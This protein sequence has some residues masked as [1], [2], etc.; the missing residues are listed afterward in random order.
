[1]ASF[2][3]PK[4]SEQLGTPGLEADFNWK[5]LKEAFLWRYKRTKLTRKRE[6]G[7]Y[8]IR[9]DTF[10][11]KTGLQDARLD[12]YS[13]KTLVAT[14]SL[15][16]AAIIPVPSPTAGFQISLKSGKQLVLQPESEVSEDQVAWVHALQIATVMPGVHVEDILVEEERAASA[17]TKQQL[18]RQQSISEAEGTTS[19]QSEPEPKPLERQGSD[20]VALAQD[21]E[22]E[23]DAAAEHGSSIAGVVPDIEGVS[24]VAHSGQGEQPV[25]KVEDDDVVTSQVFDYLK[26][27]MILLHERALA[28][29]RMM[30]VQRLQ[31]LVESQSARFS[32]LVNAVKASTPE[33][34]QE[35]RLHRIARGQLDEADTVLS[36]HITAFLS[37]TFNDTLYERNYLLEYA[38]SAISEWCRE[39]HLDFSFV[40]MRW[41]ISSSGLQAVD[42]CLAEVADCFTTRESTCFVSLLSHRRGFIPIPSRIAPEGIE[43]AKETLMAMIA[44]DDTPKGDIE[45]ALEFINTQYMLDNN[46]VPVA[47]QLKEGSAAISTQA[48]E[49]LARAV[50]GKDAVGISV[51]AM[52]VQHALSIAADAKR[53]MVV[54]KRFL[55]ELKF[56]S[57]P[58]ARACVDHEGWSDAA[59]DDINAVY[60]TLCKNHQVP[61]FEFKLMWPVGEAMERS[62]SFTD[63]LSEFCLQVTR[64]IITSIGVTLS[65]DIRMLVPQYARTALDHVVA[66]R[67]RVSNPSLV[68][69]AAVMSD[70]LEYINA[71]HAAGELVNPLAIVGQSGAGK[72]TLL[73][74]IATHLS[75]SGNCKDAVVVRFA[76]MDVKAASLTR[77]LSLLLQ[78]LRSL[79]QSKFISSTTLHASADQS[80]TTQFTATTSAL[81]TDDDTPTEFSSIIAVLPQY[82]AN[83]ASVL[84]RLV[85][86]IDALDEYVDEQNRLDERVG[87]QAWLPT[88]L[89]SNVR[90]IVT[91]EMDNEAH[92]QLTALLPESAFYQLGSMTLDEAETCLSQTLKGAGRVL[93][94]E[95]QAAIGTALEQCTLPLFV[96]MLAQKAIGWTSFESDAVA[97]T[98]LA[99]IIAENLLTAENQ[100][101]ESLVRHALRYLSCARN[102]LSAVELQHVLSATPEVMDTLNERWEAPQGVVPIHC[103]T[104]LQR[105]LQGQLMTGH[106]GSLVWTHR[107][108]QEGVRRRYIASPELEIEAQKQIMAVFL[109]QLQDLSEHRQL[110]ESGQQKLHRLCETVP[111]L[112]VQCNDKE[113]LKSVLLIPQVFQTLQKEMVDNSNYD[114]QQFI[115]FLG[116]SNDELLAQSLSRFESSDVT[117]EA[118]DAQFFMQGLGEYF[119]H[120]HNY[121]LASKAVEVS[122]KFFKSHGMEM[123]ESMGD[124]LTYQTRC[125]MMQGNSRLALERAKE[126]LAVRKAVL[127]ENHPAVGACYTNIAIAYKRLFEPELA[128]EMYTKARALFEADDP[129]EGNHRLTIVLLD[130][131]A[132]YSSTERLSEAED[133]YMQVLHRRQKTLGESVA[134]AVP[135]N[136]LA[137]LRWRQERFPEAMDYISAAIEMRLKLLGPAHIK[138]AQSMSV[139]AILFRDM[140]DLQ[141]AYNI[142]QQVTSVFENNPN[143]VQSSLC[144]AYATLAE[145]SARLNLLEDAERYLTEAFQLTDSDDLNTSNADAQSAAGDVAAAQGNFRKALTHYQTAIDFLTKVYKTSER[146]SIKRIEQKVEALTPQLGYVAMTPD[147][148]SIT[149]EVA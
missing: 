131:A 53:Q 84:D 80:A 79:G 33:L 147:D 102:G 126:S 73:S 68:P 42:N 39:F 56:D 63:Y 64:H 14:Y 37:S 35:M 120:R 22:E 12:R 90:L 116:I 52:E 117:M 92:K 47:Y 61:S 70:V 34:D 95:Q 103:I 6:I 30:L 76:G 91:A 71:T 18:H 55:E 139:K 97:P 133:L 136:N 15:V 88:L 134:T 140:G 142:M 110:K 43:S 106:S 60:E 135:L 98:S 27:P 19:I 75:K 86:V 109:K 132:L 8:V 3:K 45:E 26:R 145:L 16:G 114:L 31:E 7:W 108:Y 115:Q 9:Q 38:A 113:T 11:H 81:S 59:Q 94:P 137:V 112:C 67:S 44:S 41:G 85:I 48:K 10:R 69:R 119:L 138:T 17:Y 50:A 78:Q 36:P 104:S 127:G 65:K 121:N 96:R 49:M 25:V 125:A 105:V 46:S 58:F 128:L 2:L 129:G 144:N 87:L 83:A 32:A 146:Q 54:F 111:W 93:Q 21:S 118:E 122:I 101:G 99:D 13:G 62:I 123:T 143:A 149:A 107:Q 130:L 124:A 51:T 77:T 89:P 82:I 5:T 20:F 28:S 29:H 24:E 72:S 74:Q 40:D 148:E 23:E 57:S 66:A 4:P 141:T 1:M 100:I